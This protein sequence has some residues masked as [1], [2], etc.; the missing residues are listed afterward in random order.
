MTGS[1][2]RN[3]CVISICSMP[4]FSQTDPSQ[5]TVD[6][7]HFE[8]LDVFHLEHAS[9]PLAWLRATPEDGRYDADRDR[10]PVGATLFW[11]VAYF[12]IVAFF[13]RG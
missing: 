11:I 7:K 5:Q 8:L 6:D 9:D 10:L 2:I 12:V 4:L 3:F 13:S 1:I